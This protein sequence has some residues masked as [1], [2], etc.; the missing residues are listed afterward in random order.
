MT[1]LSKLGLPHLLILFSTSMVSGEL[2]VVLSIFY[3]NSYLVEIVIVIIVLVN[4]PT[5]EEH[6]P[7][8]GMNHKILVRM[9]WDAAILLPELAFL[10]REW[11]PASRPLQVLAPSTLF[12]DIIPHAFIS[13]H[14]AWLI[15]L[16]FNVLEISSKRLKRT[17]IKGIFEGHWRYLII[18]FEWMLFQP[19]N[20]CILNDDRLI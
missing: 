11:V 2:N 12:A 5:F 14:L 20:T 13:V 15:N 10:C 9:P 6:L 7:S 1:R 16:F 17:L 4:Y 18:F 8:R 3:L 19:T